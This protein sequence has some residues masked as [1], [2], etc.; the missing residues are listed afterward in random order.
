MTVRMICLLWIAA[1]VW[2]QTPVR[3]NALPPRQSA[4]AAVKTA[5]AQAAPV[6]TATPAQAATPAPATPA[7]AQ[8]APKP[9]TP[10]QAAPAQTAPAQPAP[11]EQPPSAATPKPSSPEGGYELNLQTAP[12]PQV[13]DILARRLRI[14]YILDPKIKGGSVTLN[15]YGQIRQ[16]D[17]LSLLETILRINGAAMVQVGEMYRIVPVNEVGRLP[18]SPQTDMKTPSNDEHMT[19]NLVFLKYATVSEIQKLIDP[20]IGEGG[21]AVSYEPANL[22]LL[23]D[24]ARNMKRTMELIGLFD[25]DTLAAKRVRLFDVKNGQPSDLA[26]ELETV[27]KAVSLTGE[28]SAATVKFLPIDRINT[29]VAIAPNPG[30]FDQVAEWLK[31][32]DIEP[33]PT[34]GTVSNYVYR[35][36]YGWA[37]ML[38]MAI[39]QLYFGYPSMGM[40]MGGMGMGMGMGGGMGMGMGG[41]GY[42]GMGMGGMSQSGGFGGGGYGGMGGMGMGGMGYGGMGMGGMGYGGYGGGMGYGSPYGA[43]P[44][45]AGQAGV[46]AAGTGTAATTDLTGSYLGAGVPG[47]ISAAKVPRVIPNPFDNTLLIQATP[48]DYQQVVKLLQQLD[49]P[50]RQVLVEAKIYEV[51]LTGSFSSGVQAYLNQVNAAATS[52]VPASRQL[53][54]SLV[55]PQTQLTAGLL[56]GTSRQLLGILT[57]SEQNKRA[58]LVSAPSIIATDSIP[59][60]IN[61]GDQVPTLSAQAVGNVQALGNST[62]TQSIQNVQSGVTLDVVARVTPGGI[63]TMKINQDVSTPVAPDVGAAIQSPSFQKRTMSTQITVQDGDTVAIGGIILDTDTLSSSGIPFLHRIPGIGAAFGGKSVTKS[64]TEL[65]IFFTPRVIYDTNQM[66]E[67][68]EELKSKFKRLQSVI[69]E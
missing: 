17:T 25:N 16:V 1:A 24:N 35:V 46:G 32:L 60:R 52:G 15:T 4:P 61:V 26:K 64:R 41:M 13:I 28:K 69:Q 55:P 30:V 65:V 19:L 27:M 37:E 44:L 10:A 66:V 34:A 42:G 3:P 56:V 45:A 38:S 21:K 67:A 23:L 9:A 29:I 14:N 7:P 50:P 8:T 40:G 49:V 62:F 36:K 48:Q 33:K 2:A 12:L 51:D 53:L 59:A 6:Q 47:M 54:G 57:L 68:S 31:R 20:F 39:M 5:P 58:K 63:I 18:I 43:S 22:L 11:Q